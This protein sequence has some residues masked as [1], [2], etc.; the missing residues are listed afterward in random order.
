MNMTSE[1]KRLMNI[2]MRE[3]RGFAMEVEEIEFQFKAGTR[4]ICNFCASLVSFLLASLS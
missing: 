4:V 3:R 1:K 2:L